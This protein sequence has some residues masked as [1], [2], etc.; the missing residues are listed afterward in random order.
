MLALSKYISDFLN[1]VC[2]EIKYKGV[3]G[4]ISTELQG[5]IYEIMENY[6]ESGMDKDRAIQKAVE[7]MGDPI[8]IGKELNKT[9]RPKTEWS[10]ILLIG[11]MVLI[12]GITLFS[13][14]I[15]TASSINFDQFFKSYLVYTLIGIGA[16]MSCYF[17]D[18]TKLEKYSIYIFISN[19]AF[20]FASA[21]FG[22]ELSGTQFIGIVKIRFAYSTIALPFFLTSFSGLANKWS[23]G[24]IKDMLKLLTLATLAV[25]CTLYISFTTAILLSAGFLIIITKAILNKGFKGNRKRFLFSIYGGGITL[26]SMLLW[27][28]NAVGS[29]YKATRLFIFLNPHLDPYEIGFISNLLKYIMLPNAKLFGKSDNLYFN[30]QG[31]DRMVLPEANTDLVFA[32]IV[33]AFGWIVGIITIIV[34]VLAITRMFLAVRKI[35]HQYGRYL[36]SAIVSV[37]SLQALASVLINTGRLPI[38]SFSLPF[39]S[40]GGIN[41]VINMALMGLLLSV[42]RRKDLVTIEKG[43]CQR[44]GS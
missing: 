25:I 32:Y 38:S 23:T 12:G 42:Y 16:F 20:L 41:F 5:H 3:H 9:H 34:I 10:I 19:I 29:N 18:Y 6:I 17:F 44:S 22:R 35:N 26:I 36:A 21:I 7:Q 28:N 15:D 2:G 13:V 14:A 39:I 30:H 37:F 40:Y 8:G 1:K 11:A 4:N 27:V 31:V 33:S 43:Y 24:S